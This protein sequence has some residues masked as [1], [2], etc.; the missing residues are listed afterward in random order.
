LIITCSNEGETLEPTPCHDECSA[1][2]GKQLTL[3]S[4]KFLDVSNIDQ[5]ALVPRRHTAAIIAL[6]RSSRRFGIYR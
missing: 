4:F 6:L 1:K 3:T 2:A 5:P